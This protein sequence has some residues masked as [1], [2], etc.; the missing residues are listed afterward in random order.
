MVRSLP[1]LLITLVGCG[2]TRGFVYYPEKTSVVAPEGLED[3]WFTSADGTEL[4]G[5]LER[6]E[7]ANRALLYCHGNGGNIEG[8]AEELHLLAR[9]TSASVLGFDYR[10][11]GRSH[12][13]PEEKGVCEDAVAALAALERETGIV[14]SRTIVLGHSL[15]G[16]V[17][18]DLAT[19]RPEIGGLVV[20][21]SFTSLDDVVRHLTLPGLGLLIP[22]SWD[23]IEKVPSIAA[24]KLFLH[25]D[26]DGLIPLEQGVALHAAA[27]PPKRL[28]IVEGG[29]HDDILFEPDFARALCTF[30][31][32][33]CR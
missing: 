24:P 22:E 7:G 16:A 8:R 25:G 31:E 9:V 19:R 21:S 26:R 13:E 17:A 18:I 28:V 33:V 20:V 4:H 6:R 12:G 14:A 15:G 27:A 32:G 1:L 23:S 30:T 2:S 5:W 10:G 3:V 29:G 11:F